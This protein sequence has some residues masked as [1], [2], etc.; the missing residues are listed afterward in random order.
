MHPF[1]PVDSIVRTIW[2]DADTILLVFAGSAAEFALNR[3]VDWLFYTGKLP[4]DPLGRLSSTA[5]FAQEIV[6]ADE[7]SARRT[8]GRIRAVHGAVE[9]SRGE[10]IPDWAHRDVFYMLIDYSERAFSLLHRPLTISEQSDL[11]DVFLRVGEGLAISKL[12][13]TYSEWTVD[14]GLHLERDLTYSEL[15]AELYDRYRRNLGWWRYEALLR[16]QGMLLPDHVLRLLSL[17][18]SHWLRPMVGAYRV[19]VRVRLR[20]LVHRFV[21]PPRVL[22]DVRLLDYPG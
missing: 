4:N 9:R 14:R 1:V 16:V 21:M 15:T 19:M 5:R 13:R 12:P 22:P 11:Y 20:P 3:A 7:E 6:F 17:R 18:S 8:L 2:R 10:A